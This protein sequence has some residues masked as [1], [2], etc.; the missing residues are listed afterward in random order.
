M[1]DTIICKDGNGRIIINSRI[2]FIS[3]VIMILIT[4]ASI[5]ALTVSAQSDIEF[6]KS[7]ILDF[8]NKIEDHEKRITTIE[9]HYTHISNSLERIEKKIE[10]K[11]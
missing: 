2:A 6:A 7:N 5:V 4:F 11:E 9:T 10:A 3:L 8:K 1:A